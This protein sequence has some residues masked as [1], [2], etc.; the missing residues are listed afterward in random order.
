MLTLLLAVIA[1]ACSSNSEL[2]RVKAAAKRGDAEA[3]VQLG[4]Y[5]YDGPELSPDYHAAALWFAR[6]AQQGH[7]GAQFALGKMMVNAE[8]MLPD[9]MQGASW[10]RKAAEQGYAPAQDELARMYANGTGLLQDHAEALKWA[11]QAA[12][13]GFT[14]AQ[15]YLGCLLYSN[16]PAAA[17]TDKLEACFWLAV[18]AADGHQ[19]SE[20]MLN[21]LKPQ[22]TAAQSNELK[23]RVEE[24]KKNHAAH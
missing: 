11:T 15:Y 5:Y 23:R 21:T 20:D 16:A 9:E 3:Q 14:D 18:A 24:W 4:S 7:P 12:K 17:S 2:D 1:S 19:E 10:I 6:A 8:G 13:Q 22:L